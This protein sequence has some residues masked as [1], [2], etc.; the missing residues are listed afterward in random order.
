MSQETVQM[1]FLICV[2]IMYISVSWRQKVT[3]YLIANF[4]RILYQDCRPPGLISNNVVLIKIK[5]HNKN[6]EN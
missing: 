6:K 4:T 3:K 5:M 2:C 1:M